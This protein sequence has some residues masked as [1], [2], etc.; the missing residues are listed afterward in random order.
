M[1]LNVIEFSIDELKNGKATGG[2]KIANEFLKVGKEELGR[3]LQIMF[4]IISKSERIPKEWKKVR[5]T[6]LHKGG[7]IRGFWIIIGG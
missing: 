1:G 6:M 4:N 3:S 2:D 7:G 5:I